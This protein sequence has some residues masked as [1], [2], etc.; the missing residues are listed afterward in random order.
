[1]LQALSRQTLLD[2]MHSAHMSMLCLPDMAVHQTA[3]LIAQSQSCYHHVGALFPLQLL[4]PWTV[5]PCNWHHDMLYVRWQVLFALLGQSVRHDFNEP[6]QKVSS[7][8]LVHHQLT[9]HQPLH[10]QAPQPLE[11]RTTNLSRCLPCCRL[12]ALAWLV[13]QLRACWCCIGMV[14]YFD[15]AGALGWGKAT[16]MLQA[17]H[18]QVGGKVGGRLG[19]A[20]GSHWFQL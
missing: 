3:D 4:I 5:S 12:F 1:M 15:T 7:V 9:T 8:F 11:T 2:V 18:L 6:F 19:P 10:H 14:Q 17:P 13:R 20:A 16:Q